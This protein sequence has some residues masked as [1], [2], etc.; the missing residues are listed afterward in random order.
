MATF[1]AVGLNLDPW[2]AHF[3]A[4]YSQGYSLFDFLP[5][6]HALELT[7]LSVKEWLGLVVYQW[8]SWAQRAST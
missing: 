2:P 1:R 7:T 5:D 4:D 3:R 6:A 8:L